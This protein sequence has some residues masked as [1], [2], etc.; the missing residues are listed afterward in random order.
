MDYE[1][2]N[3]EKVRNN[4]IGTFWCGCCDRALVREGRKCK[5][6]GFK[7]N[8]RRAPLRDVKKSG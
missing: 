2:T 5:V 4:N 8:N 6:C 1:P 7:N 3:R